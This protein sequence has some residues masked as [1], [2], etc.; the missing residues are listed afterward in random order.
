VTIDIDTSILGD[1]SI[2]SLRTL[3]DDDIHAVNT[4]DDQNRVTLASNDSARS[5]NGVVTVTLPPV[6]WSALTLA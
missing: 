2:D 1:V 6:S 4:R 5:S 3:H